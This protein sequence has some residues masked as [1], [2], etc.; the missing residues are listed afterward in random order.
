MA[1]AVDPMLVTL[2][3]HSA[4]NLVEEQSRCD[5]EVVQSAE[6]RGGLKMTRANNLDAIFSGEASGFEARDEIVL[7]TGA[8]IA[9]LQAIARRQLV[10]SIV[11]AVIIAMASVF[12]ALRPAQESAQ[13]WSRPVVQ[14]PIFEKAGSEVAAVKRFE[15]P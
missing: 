9:A 4:P 6:G 14:A 15:L 8:E 11:I 10:G 2:C 5:I 13:T 3:H 12:F 7:G 1:L